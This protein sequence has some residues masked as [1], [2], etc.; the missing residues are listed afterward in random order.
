MKQGSD[1]KFIFYC[2]TRDKTR[3]DLKK[4]EKVRKKLTSFQKK[5]I[6]PWLSVTQS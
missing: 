5:V 2:E 6:V 3:A 1:G 4:D